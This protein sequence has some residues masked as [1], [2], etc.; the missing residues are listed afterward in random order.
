KHSIFF[1]MTCLFLQS[2]L[3]SNGETGQAISLFNGED[4]NG[5]Y[6]F[7]ENRGR[8]ND[9][10]QVFTVVDGMIRISGEEWGCITTQEEFEN[11]KITL[12]FKWGKKTFAPRVDKARDSGLLLHSV[13]EDGGKEG[14]WMHSIECQMIEGGTGDFIVVGDGSTNFSLIAPVSKDKQNGSYIYDSNGLPVTIN[15]GRV[16]WYAR[17]PVWKDTI[18]FRGEHDVE[19]PLGEW[20]V[21]ECHAK[22]EEIYVYLNGKLVNYAIRVKPTK[23][24]IQIQSE[25]A[26]LFVRKV[27]L[28]K[29]Q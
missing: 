8:D 11:Y 28:E 17:S 24:K 12:E 23:G 4:F 20:N 29:L 16:N 3:S 7:L 18:N 27:E 26:E 25:G 10:K 6:K 22:G 15:D 5:W 1:F 13:G 9:P 2:C 21:L 19:K 14:I